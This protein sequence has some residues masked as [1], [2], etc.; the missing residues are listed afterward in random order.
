MV[1]LKQILEKCGVN[2][3]NDLTDQLQARLNRVMTLR[4]HESWSLFT[5]WTTLSLSVRTANGVSFFYR[6]QVF[7]ELITRRMDTHFSICDMRH[8]RRGKWTVVFEL[9]PHVILLVVSNV[10]E[11]RIATIFRTREI[12]ERAARWSKRKYWNTSEEQFRSF[13]RAWSDIL[14]PVVTATI[15]S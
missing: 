13:C 6:F 12:L 2:L 8:S 15:C 9:W 3:W 7:G 4:F 5:V 11:G 1:I 14:T 10:S